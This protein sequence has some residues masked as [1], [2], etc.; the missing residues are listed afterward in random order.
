[1]KSPADSESINMKIQWKKLLTMFKKPDAEIRL[2][3]WNNKNDGALF[4]V[5]A[6]G[7]KFDHL[8]MFAQ[9]L[10]DNNELAK[11]LKDAVMM[12]NM[13]TMKDMMEKIGKLG[14]MFDP[15]SDLDKQSKKKEKTIN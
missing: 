4:G 9:L 3:V 8:V 7:S 13:D 11:I 14:Q 6:Y 1:M 10:D 2:R 12:K 15:I 5:Q